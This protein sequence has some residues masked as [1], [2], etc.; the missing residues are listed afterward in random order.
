MAARQRGE[1][2]P[3]LMI[4]LWAPLRLAGIGLLLAVALWVAA[5]GLAWVALAR[6]WMA[7]PQ[8]LVELLA[9][10]SRALQALSPPPTAAS[11]PTDRFLVIGGPV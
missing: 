10:E 3:A 11:W 7:G 6:G 1:D 4:V 5:C 8:V 9:Q 2:R